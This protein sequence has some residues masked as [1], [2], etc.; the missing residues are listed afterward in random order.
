MATHHDP[1]TGIPAFHYLSETD[2]RT[3]LFT[4]TIPSS[5]ARVMTVEGTERP[6]IAFGFLMMSLSYWIELLVLVFA[7]M[8]LG[9]FV[10]LLLHH[11]VIKPKQEGTT[12]AYL[13]G[14]GIVLP[15]WSVFSFL[16]VE[17]F[18]ARNMIFKFMMG[19]FTVVYFF[20][21]IETICGFS[22]E[23]VKGSA[24]DFCFY[25]ATIPIMAR[26]KAQ[27]ARPPQKKTREDGTN[28]TTNDDGDSD[29]ITHNGNIGDQIP[30]T[31]TKI[32]KH[33]VT[34]TFLLLALGLLQSILSPFLDFALF[35]MESSNEDVA[36]FC[37]KESCFT[38]RL[39]ANSAIQAFLLQMYL[40]TYLEALTF[41]FTAF[42]G[43]EAEP[44]MD[45]PLLA[46]QSPSE[47]WGRRWN[48][49]VH[50]VLK[51]GVYKP[52]RKTCSS[53]TAAVI[54]TFLASGIFHEWLLLMV[55]PNRFVGG[56]QHHDGS[57]KNI[58]RLEFGGT[59]IF[60]L[61]QA[62]L[63]GFE[64]T[65]GKS[66]LFQRISRWVP[67]PLKTAFVVGTGIPLAHF[68]LEPYVRSDFFR[69]GAPGLP[70]VILI[71]K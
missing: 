32:L 39:Y 63:I 38:W 12:K 27:K 4:F 62:M 35:R 42:T 46:S 24:S 44:V 7:M 3:P 70:M 69:H 14:W 36:S 22:P 40:T 9:A 1:I 13:V 5:I 34:F 57:E 29:L 20:R 19:C 43:Y 47:F 68:F 26:I 53:K 23:Y 41:L 18:D 51:N 45:N 52:I 66:Q 11:A 30:C 59:T 65:L 28:A 60:F 58:Y 17:I 49:L 50:T 6:D 25:Y 71:P 33:F 56:N 48:L 21:T 31:S 10:G 67:R 16:V 61:W 2:D 15:F 55:F 8:S 64:M 54:S 37:A